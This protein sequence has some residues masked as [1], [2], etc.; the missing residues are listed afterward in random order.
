MILC[1]LH[2]TVSIYILMMMM[3]NQNKESKPYITIYRASHG[4]DEIRSEMLMASER[5]RRLEA[6]PRAIRALAL[7]THPMQPRI[8]APV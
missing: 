4:G 1:E 6:G 5:V 7:L 2:D 8:V 3:R